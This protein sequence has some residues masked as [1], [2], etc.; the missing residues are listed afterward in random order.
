M[1][2]RL[3]DAYL[4]VNRAAI[5]LANLKR[6]TNRYLQANEGL[7]VIK[8]EG[9]TVSG[10]PP[11]DPP[12]PFLGILIGESVQNL[13]TALDYLVYQLA[14]WDSGPDFERRTQFPIEDTPKGFKRRRNSFLEGVSD[15]HVAV[16]DSLQPYERP[17]WLSWIRELSNLDKH[18]VLI[19]T[20][21][22]Q[23][24]VT[25]PVGRSDEEA[26]A[27]GGFRRPGEVGMYFKVPMHIAFGD[28][29]PVI[30]QLEELKTE[31]RSLLQLFEPE[32]E[33]EP[34]HGS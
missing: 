29:F 6:R 2:G 22:I 34:T 10:P 9:L 18:N 32:L 30:E 13:R 7:A 26:I 3:D 4:R 17:N 23:G 31:T 11:F 27:A 15:E 24:S 12:P 8:V 33:G 16:L 19:V 28:G 1:P 5:H 20:P 21:G 14:E 25:I